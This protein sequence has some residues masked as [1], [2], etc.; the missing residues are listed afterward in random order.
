MLHDP[1]PTRNVQRCP[2]TLVGMVRTSSLLYQKHL[3]SHMHMYKKN[4]KSCNLLF[5][6]CSKREYSL[7]AITARKRI[8]Q[9]E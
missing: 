7:L 5:S 6:F 4:V 9:P 1:P 3:Q 8:A 2:L